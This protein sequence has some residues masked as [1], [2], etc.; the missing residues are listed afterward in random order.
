MIVA[1]WGAR[2]TRTLESAAPSR[3]AWNNSPAPDRRSAGTSREG[4]PPFHR[5]PTEA[6]AVQGLTYER[7]MDVGR[8]GRPGPF[9]GETRLDCLFH[10]SGV[11]R[12]ERGGRIALQAQNKLADRLRRTSLSAVPEGNLTPSRRARPLGGPRGIA[13]DRDG[14]RRSRGEEFVGMASGGGRGDMAEGVGF[15]PTVPCGTAVFKTAALNHSATP[16][17]VTGQ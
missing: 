2:R 15:E 4:P 16:P 3:T 1:P 13:R 11:I 6:P 8:G 10:V 14:T 5:L 7:V 9:N 17:R 12:A